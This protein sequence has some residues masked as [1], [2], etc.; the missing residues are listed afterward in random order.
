MAG[1]Q[2]AAHQPAEDWP[3]AE[4]PQPAAIPGEMITPTQ[5]L[6]EQPSTEQGQRTTFA[7]ERY[8]TGESA[9]P[10]QNQP[11][12][13][14]DQQSQMGPEMKPSYSPTV[15]KTAERRYTQQP[16][17]GEEESGYSE[18]QRSKRKFMR[19]TSEGY[20]P[21]EKDHSKEDNGLQWR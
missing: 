21:P 14:T 19:Y 18:Q 15:S 20:L 17:S 10:F 6:V 1:C 2:A 11:M 8:H 3:S 5:I 12:Y 7:D 4:A 13:A 9:P 16:S